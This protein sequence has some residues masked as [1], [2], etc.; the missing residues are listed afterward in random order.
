MSGNEMSQILFLFA[1]PVMVRVKRRPFW[2]AVGLGFSGLGCFMMA[3]PHW[4][5]VTH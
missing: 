3:I 5:E 4:A 1:M 2:T